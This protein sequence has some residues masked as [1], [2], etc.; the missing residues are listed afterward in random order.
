MLSAENFGNGFTVFV[1][2]S[3]P[4]VSSVFNCL[5]WSLPIRKESRV[6]FSISDVRSMGHSWV[7]E[8]ENESWPLPYTIHTIQVQMIV[9]PNVKEYNNKRL[10]EN[11]QELLHKL[12]EANS[13]CV[14]VCVS[15]LNWIALCTDPLKSVLPSKTSPPLLIQKYPVTISLIFDAPSSSLHYAIAVCPQPM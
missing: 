15:L 3:L 9:D 13:V 6:I 8:S 1:P 7:G 4:Y 10:K 5:C 2:L 12:R 11:I 14:C